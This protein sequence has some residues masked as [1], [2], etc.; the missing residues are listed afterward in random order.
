MSTNWGA[1]F[2]ERQED[3][4]VNRYR[5]FNTFAMLS[6]KSSTTTV[7]YVWYV[8]FCRA[9]ETCNPSSVHTSTSLPCTPVHQYTKKRA[10]MLALQ[11]WDGLRSRVKAPLSFFF[12]VMSLG[13]AMM[14]P[15]PI[16]QHGFWTNDTA[17]RPEPY[18]KNWC[19]NKLGVCVECQKKN[20]FMHLT[21]L[22]A[23]VA[24]Y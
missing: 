17:V 20:I 12:L 5:Y 4:R 15:C 19:Q 3:M 22:R 16:F 1:L 24:T 14:A 2:L 13:T 11:G 18:R 8:C 23:A 10:R 9:F 21:H 7:L 6:G